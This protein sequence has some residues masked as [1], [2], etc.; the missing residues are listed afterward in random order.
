MVRH[1]AMRLLARPAWVAIRVI[2]EGSG[3]RDHLRGER[4]AARAKAARQPEGSGRRVDG[5]EG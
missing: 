4:G 5:G 3:C 1:G 2:I